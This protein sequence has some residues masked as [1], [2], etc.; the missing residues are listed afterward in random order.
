MGK[1]KG[2]KKTSKVRSVRPLTIQ[3]R[4]NLYLE[5]MFKLEEIKIWN[6]GD[7]G[8]QR[9]RIMMKLWKDHGK[10]FEGDV[11][12]ETEGRKL[13]YKLYNDKNKR[14]VAYISR[15]AYIDEQKKKENEEKQREME[16]MESKQMVDLPV[17]PEELKKLREKERAEADQT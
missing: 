9:F 6:S 3:E 16:N 11:N 8:M 4:T 5:I 7:P 12:L 15:N 2:G 1:K 17:D 14:T 13:I 10:E